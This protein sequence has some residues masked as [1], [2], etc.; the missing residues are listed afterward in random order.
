[1]TVPSGNMEKGSFSVRGWL[2]GYQKALG[3]GNS[4]P[5]PKGFGEA[6]KVKISAVL[7]QN[8]KCCD[9]RRIDIFIFYENIDFY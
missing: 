5:R 9:L 1:M 6:N 8:P 7:S 4:V 2:S 3:R